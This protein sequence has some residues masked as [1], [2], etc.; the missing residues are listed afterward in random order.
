MMTG[1]EVLMELLHKEDVEYIFGLP[2]ATEVLFM[3]AL[4]K[5]PEMRYIL[6]LNEV[7]VA[8]MAEGYARMSGKPG[9]LNLHT[10]AGVAAAMPMLINARAGGVPLVVTAGQQDSRILLKD[11]PLSGDLLGMGRF[12]SKW[13]AEILYADDI[14]M[15]IQRS[16]KM[17]MQPPAGPVFLSIPQNIMDQSIDF[18]Y[19]PNKLPFTKLRPDLDAINEAVELL[20]STKIPAIV[21]GSGV[22][23]NNALPEVVKLAELIG[24]RV[25]Q[26]WMADVNFPV[27]HPQYIGDF[28]PSSPETKKLLEQVDLL[29]GIGCQL[30]SLP[31]HQPK[32][33]LTKH[34]KIVQLDDNPWEIAKNFPVTV[35]IQGD[36]KESLKELINILEKDMPARAEESAKNRVKEIT[37]EKEAIT[38]A[39]YKQTEA[40]KDNV[41]ISVSRLMRELRDAIEPGTVVVDECWSASKML[42]RTLDFT[43]AKSFQRTRGGGSIGWGLP[44]S[45]GIK[46][47]TP[48]CPVVVVCGDG[49]AMWSNQ[50]L[51]T[52]AHYNIPVTFI[53]IANANYR[54]V[55]IMRKIILGGELNEKHE[56]MDLD[57][58]VIDFCQLAESMGVHGDKVEQPDD[59]GKTLKAAF[60]SDEPRLIEVQVENKKTP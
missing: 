43:E 45:L 57:A 35:G 36:I 58:P 11:P 59:L 31:F 9:I 26:P 17:A 2:G 5:Y 7:V 44:G 56:G 27:Q 19:I 55:K 40:E 3:D 50:S 33:I 14:P 30:F 21:V 41:P 46:L 34:T 12:F 20:I 54:Q 48:E 29:V 49:S 8:G 4:E 6:G 38:A 60:D 39:F 16:F 15:V 22:A 47:A 10:G 28:E 18:E 52:A 24:A 53:V 51:W 25:Y 37:G 1:K 13:Q 23:R 42:S 32:P